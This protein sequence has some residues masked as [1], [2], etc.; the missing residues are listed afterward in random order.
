MPSS[1]RKIWTMSALLAAS[2]GRKTFFETLLQL[3]A[4]E[5]RPLHGIPILIKVTALQLRFRK[6]VLIYLGQYCYS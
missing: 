5:G 6:H 3:E 4:N 1:L 2:E